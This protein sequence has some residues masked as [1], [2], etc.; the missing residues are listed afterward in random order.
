MQGVFL[1]NSEFVNIITYVKFCVAAH[2]SGRTGAFIRRPSS[3]V[4][5]KVGQINVFTGWWVGIKLHCTLLEIFERTYLVSFDSLRQ[6]TLIISNVIDALYSA[7]LTWLATWF[8]YNNLFFN[9]YE[10]GEKVVHLIGT[11]TC[12]RIRNH[13]KPS[14]CRPSPRII[15]LRR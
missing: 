9:V 1:I 3:M 15:L 7:L 12:D 5:V 8:N 10:I 13:P 14:E 2:H 6:L 4:S 11:A